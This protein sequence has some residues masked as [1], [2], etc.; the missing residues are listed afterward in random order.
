MND[1]DGTPPDR[2]AQI[3]EEAGL[4]AA[5]MHGE[6]AE[7]YR[8]DFAIWLRTSPIHASVYSKAMTAHRESLRI[9]TLTGYGPDRDRAR[10][11]DLARRAFKRQP[12]WATKG[13]MAASLVL[14]AGLGAG[15]YFR[16]LHSE[17]TREHVP[18]TLM[19]MTRL[20]E[21]R[22]FHLPDGSSLTL[23]TDS[24]VEVVINHQ[25]RRLRLLAGRMRLAIASAPQP[26]EIDAGSGRI[27][28]PQGIFDLMIAANHE[29]FLRLVSGSAKLR[30]LKP[31]DNSTASAQTLDVGNAIRIPPDH[32]APSV[33]TTLPFDSADWPNGWLD[34]RKIALGD[35]IDLANR[36]SSRPLVLSAPEAARTEVTGR[37]KIANTAN[38]V[39]N[40]ADL[41]G[42]T[43]SE[44]AQEIRLRGK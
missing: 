2:L 31:I 40:I 9:S 14:G 36:Y 4:W 12:L 15:I 7:G 10:E 25:R 43:V 33:Q 8:H 1:N 19:L 23:D 39:R 20:G 38:F 3:E 11:L 29:L 22:T 41:Y 44:D 28:A 24:R 16:Q 26:F 42:L 27:D 21:I 18:T 37:F 30:P 35:L 6:N 5:R 32:F 13:A 34:C 17:Q